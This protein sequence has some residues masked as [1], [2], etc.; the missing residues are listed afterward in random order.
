M[1]EQGSNNSND[2][3]GQNHGEAADA[4]APVDGV[5]RS[6]PLG[7]KFAVASKYIQP[8]TFSYT[9]LNF[10]FL[11]LN[12]EEEVAEAAQKDQYFANRAAAAQGNQQGQN[13][14]LPQRDGMKVAIKHALQQAFLYVWNFFR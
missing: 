1:P 13:G 5:H 6:T 3:S 14:T 2:N 9:F 10:F 7:R 4:S 8:K 12:D 11:D